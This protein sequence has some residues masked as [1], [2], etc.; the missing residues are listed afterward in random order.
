[1]AKKLNEIEEAPKVMEGA[2]GRVHNLDEDGQVVINPIE[3]VLQTYKAGH[4]SLEEAEGIL[5]QLYSYSFL[6]SQLSYGM[7]EI[8]GAPTSSDSALTVTSKARTKIGFK[9][10]NS[11]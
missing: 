9:Q 4:L 3:V 7:T 5:D 6:S 1:M 11:L 2:D 8:G 10:K